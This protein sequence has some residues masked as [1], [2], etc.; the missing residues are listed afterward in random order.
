MLNS[1][2]TFPATPTKGRWKYQ[3]PC[4]SPKIPPSTHTYNGPL[5]MSP[6]PF[7]NV[8]KVICPFGLHLHIRMAPGDSFPPGMERPAVVPEVQVGRHTLLNARES[9]RDPW[10]DTELNRQKRYAQRGNGQLM[11]VLIPG[12]LVCR[13]SH[14]GWPQWAEP[15]FQ[16]SQCVEPL[17]P[18]DPVYRVSPLLWSQCA[19]PSSPGVPLWRAFLPGVPLCRASP[20]M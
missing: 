9:Q 1:T 12:F 11:C 8:P 16:V 14:S 19:E 3:A 15:P 7:Q 10:K 13:T 17:L 6:F 18:H 2:E 4:R 20:P 5:I